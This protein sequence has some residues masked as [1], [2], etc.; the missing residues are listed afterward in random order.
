ML[1][2]CGLHSS[3]HIHWCFDTSENQE[4]NSAGKIN[5][6][7]PVQVLNNYQTSNISSPF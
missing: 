1:Q 2:N 3:N 4:N 6:V 7:I 5:L